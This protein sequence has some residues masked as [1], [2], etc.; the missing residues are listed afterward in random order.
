MDDLIDSITDRVE[1]LIVDGIE[2]VR[3]RPGVVLAIVAGV[4][5]AFVGIGVATVMARR[6]RDQVASASNLGRTLESMSAALDLEARTRRGAK[7]VSRSTGRARRGAVSMLTDVQSAG[8]LVSVA[9]RLLE[10]PL[11]RRYIVRMVRARL[12]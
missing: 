6:K 5:G 4:L 11:V 2:L 3:E 12:S 10:N 7:R 9:L 8:D 1:D